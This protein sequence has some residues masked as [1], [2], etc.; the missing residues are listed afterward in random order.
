M[1]KVLL[2][3]VIGVL[4]FGAVN[5]SLHHLYENTGSGDANL[6]ARGIDSSLK[7]IFGGFLGHFFR[8]EFLGNLNWLFL[9]ILARLVWTWKKR[10]KVEK[11]FLVWYVLVLGVI[12][13]RGYFNFRYMI[14]LLPVTLPLIMYYGWIWMDKAPWRSVRPW[15]MMLMIPAALYNFYHYSPF[16]KDKVAPAVAVIPVDTGAASDTTQTADTPQID[17]IAQPVRHTGLF[18]RALEGDVPHLG[19]N[20]HMFRNHPRLPAGILNHMREVELKG[21]RILNNN[22]PMLYY[23]T[24]QPAVY[25]WVEDDFWYAPDGPRPLFAERTDAEMHAFII[26]SL[27][28]SHVLTLDAYHGYGEGKLKAYLD[29]HAEMTFSNEQGYEFY[30]IKR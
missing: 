3:I 15:V 12:V 11:A 20:D 16:L 30:R 7:L 29:A 2:Y 13:L 23:Y 18:R 4:L 26:D 8:F 10:S 1:R 19:Y 22:I 17:E 28:C 9:P 25:C 24:E 5:L 14:T 27:N 6:S 21:T